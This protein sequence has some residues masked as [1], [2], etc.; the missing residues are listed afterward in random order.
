[1]DR[2]ELEGFILSNPKR[3][4]IVNALEEEGTSSLSRIAKKK[5][6]P[7]KFAKELMSELVDKGVVDKDGEKYSLSDVG[8][9]IVADS[10]RF[11]SG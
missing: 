11:E 7:E 4:Q 3:R 8:E 1:M 2:E 6:I 5:R 10:H 9:K